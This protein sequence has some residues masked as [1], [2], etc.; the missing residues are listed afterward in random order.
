MLGT[1]VGLPLLASG[2][3][4]VW[5]AYQ[6]LDDFLA[7]LQ[8]EQA[9]AAAG[10]ID[11]FI[12]EIE[13]QI[14]WTVQLPWDADTV[15]QRRFDAQRLLHQVPAITELSLIDGAGKEQ[16]R[17][18]RLSSDVIGSEVD[19]SGDIRFIGA[20]AD[21][22][23]VAPVY[24]RGESE[25]HLSIGVAGNRRSAGVSIAE[26][27]LKFIW[28]IVSRIKA[29]AGG[30]A[31]VIDRDGRLIAHPDLSLVLRNTDMS[32][33]PQVQSATAGASQATV[34]AVIARN[35]TGQAV[36]SARAP[37][38]ALGWWVFVELP[39]AEAYAPIHAA[40]WR[41]AALVAIGLAIAI[42]VALA[43]ARQM[44]RPIRLLQDGARL[45]GEGEFRRAIDIRTGDE[46]EELAGQFNRMGQELEVL[47]DNLDRVNQL[48]RY[49]SPQLAE[50]IVS[51]TDSI[52]GQSH[53]RDI[54]VVFCDLRNFTA[55]STS[56]DPQVVISVLSSFYECIGG[57]VRRSGA[58]IGYFGG[59]GLMAFLND[60]L[61]CPD[62]QL[63][64]TAMAAAMSRDVGR[65]VNGW[66]EQGFGLGFGIGI[67]SGAATLGDIGSQN[68]FH[69][70]AIGPVVNLASRLCDAAENGQVL[71]TQAVRDAVEG[72]A[73]VS[74]MGER[75]LKGFPDPVPIFRLNRFNFDPE[76][77][78]NAG[79]VELLRVPG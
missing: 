28:D 33:L 3:L 24:F 2:L 12:R 19:L 5:F 54:T 79:S 27:N 67:A 40:M 70:T 23:S 51:S 47:Y 55:F 78:L 14:G 43:L 4:Q 62:H 61:P 57:W 39:E 17:V 44:V 71:M 58:T 52:V 56:C 36:L 48:K 22:Y 75:R 74:L 15:G 60:P 64:A 73:H 68:Q 11:Q 53:R 76:E 20:M 8:N 26:V 50:L 31:Y 59:D 32:G 10:R 66:R 13:S 65:L 34:R 63:R 41:S 37:I 9:N 7:R 42:G 30:T 38:P 25:P 1:L 16:V 46:L 72:S 29:G 45:I 21:K 49:F 35:L 18:S 69:Y 77:L 6:E